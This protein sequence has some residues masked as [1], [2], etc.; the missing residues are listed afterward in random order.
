MKRL[1]VL[2]SIEDVSL[3]VNTS[4]NFHNLSDSS[5]EVHNPEVSI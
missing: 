3:K 5:A 1:E 4:S 2:Y